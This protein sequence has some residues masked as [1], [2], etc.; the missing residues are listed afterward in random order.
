[1]DLSKHFSQSDL[2]IQLCPLLRYWGSS[3]T[4]YP[5]ALKWTRWMWNCVPLIQQAL[6][7][8]NHLH[9][10]VMGSCHCSTKYFKHPHISE[11]YFK[12]SSNKTILVLVNKQ[13]DMIRFC[14]WK[15]AEILVHSSVSFYAWTFEN[16]NIS[17][18]KWSSHFCSQCYAFTFTN[19]ISITSHTCPCLNLS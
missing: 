17:A 6:C 11:Q 4:L 10:T 19:Y 3:H 16:L 5:L 12:L 2:R 8:L 18:R 14:W 7:S 13:W 9:S 1:M 15:H